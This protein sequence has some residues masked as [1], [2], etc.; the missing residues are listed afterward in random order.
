MDFT[1]GS[2]THS[3]ASDDDSPDSPEIYP[4]TSFGK[5][6]LETAEARKEAERMR[7]QK[8]AARGRTNISL[9]TLAEKTRAR[10][11]DS[12][13]PQK[14]NKINFSESPEQQKEN[15]D[16]LAD[17]TIIMLSNIF[18]KNPDLDLSKFE[19]VQSLEQY[20]QELHPGPAENAAMHKLKEMALYTD[21]AV[22]KYFRNTWPQTVEISKGVSK[23]MS[24]LLSS[25]WREKVSGYAEKGKEKAKT[26]MSELKED[27]VKF[28]KKHW[29]ISG[30]T[31][32][33]GA[34][35]A[36]GIFSVIRKKFFPSPA[37]SE[38]KKEGE[39]KQA[40]AKEKKSSGFW[41]WALGIGG[42]LLALFGVGWLIGP[43]RI[44][45]FF[46]EKFGWNL[47]TNRATK[48]LSLVLEGKFGEAVNVA[49]EGIDE[50]AKSHAKM[51]AI[52]SKNMRAKVSGK[53]LF[54]LK[55]KNFEDFIST[56][57]QAQDKASMLAQEYGSQ[58][59]SWIPGIDSQEENKAQIAIRGFLKKYEKIIRDIM[60]IRE[61]T[62][63]GEVIAKLAEHQ[64]KRAAALP[65]GPGTKP[66]PQPKKPEAAAALAVAGGA[67]LAVAG[68]ADSAGIAATEA[69]GAPE[70]P[71]LPPEIPEERAA[72]T[73][74]DEYTK[75]LPEN[76]QK[77]AIAYEKLLAKQI[78]FSDI[79]NISERIE[80]IEMQLRN[81][82]AAELKPDN[83]KKVEEKLTEWLKQK[84]GFYALVENHSNKH[85]TLT[86]A[87]KQNADEKTITAKYEDFIESKE[88]IA[89]YADDMFKAQGWEELK[90]LAASHA[91]RFATFIKRKWFPANAAQQHAAHLFDKLFE[92]LKPS[93]LRAKLAPLIKKPPLVSLHTIRTATDDL[94][95]RME[96]SIVIM[97][98]VRNALRKIEQEHFELLD[99]YEQKV[100]TQQRRLSQLWKEK[101]RVL[102]AAVKKGEPTDKLLREI[103]D[104]G[105]EKARLEFNTARGCGDMYGQ[106]KAAVKGEGATKAEK[107]VYEQ[108]INKFRSFFRKTLRAQ[109]ESAIYGTERGLSKV[110]VRR[111]GLVFLSAA[112]G[113]AS[114]AALADESE[115]T[116]LVM[117]QAGLTA[118]PL[119][120]TYL[121]FYS[122]I[123]GKERITGRKLDATDRAIAAAFGVAG[124]ATDVLSVFGIGL[125]GKGALMAIKTGRAMGGAARAAKVVRAVEAGRDARTAL[126]AYKGYRA[127]EV[128]GKWGFRVALGGALGKA[129]YSLV[130]QETEQLP[131]SDDFAKDVLGGNIENTEDEVQLKKAA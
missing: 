126:K 86:E 81:L 92:C 18:Q 8:E 12:E 125:A 57:A 91:L 35:A 65:A 1:P 95:K 43:Q 40:E 48:A 61:E 129:G 115:D 45:E 15:L 47:D 70:S 123:E 26:L 29:I 84:E 52:I 37:P 82:L 119:V 128:G 109:K 117:T 102:K 16:S 130:F 62:T 50:N 76:L 4:D 96:E 33:A 7:V 25:D 41:K 39:E 59:L 74:R 89:Q 85:N 31:I 2:T 107:E 71:T 58:Y 66:L 44:K 32:L 24:A 46:K 87:L 105:K 69:G 63:V 100:L 53:T 97:D 88:L 34:F 51:A 64:E 75:N 118:V 36:Y 94:F 3:G 108:G 99:Q 78:S 11:F 127:L 20:M 113:A 17:V 38:E 111:G 19:S 104:I 5:A 27:P 10:K 114:G 110:L 112:I 93:N 14:I 23:K 67:A 54:E 6:G 131:V 120:G 116:K 83:R 60:P 42:T 9:E 79:S 124:L 98:P 90:L 72:Y 73:E 121:D 30:L 22:S 55:N 49:W 68:G 77:K 106:F 103:A 13:T 101:Y 21:S 122:A 80:E 28:A 56:G